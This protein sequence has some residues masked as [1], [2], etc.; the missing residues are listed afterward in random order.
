[1]GQWAGFGKGL[2]GEAF[3]FVKVFLFLQA[4]NDHVGGFVFAKG[5]SM[6]PTISP[7]GELLLM[8][9]ISVQLG[10]VRPGDIVVVQ[11]PLVP[12]KRVAKRLIAMGGERVTYVVDPKNSDSLNTIVVPKGHVWVEGDNIHNSYDSR[13]FGAIPYG[14]LIGRVFWRVLPFKDFGSMGPH[15]K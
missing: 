15:E 11:S 10:K 5:P 6:L 2:L 3:S 7:S 9:R 13:N 8:E 1:M 14:L 12:K 4:T